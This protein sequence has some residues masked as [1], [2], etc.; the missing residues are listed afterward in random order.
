MVAG[1]RA[2]AYLPVGANGMDGYLTRR[3]VTAPLLLLGVSFILFLLLYVRWPQ[4]PALAC[5]GP[6]GSC[7]VIKVEGSARWPDHLG[8][9]APWYERYGAWLWD[10]LRGDL[11]ESFY[12][13]PFHP[14]GAGRSYLLPP[15]AIMAI[16]GLWVLGALARDIRNP[17]L[18][19]ATRAGELARARRLSLLTLSAR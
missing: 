19:I 5:V 15:V 11:G 7:F 17:H 13:D 3:L 12:A 10:A 1:P 9:N 2:S 6:V 18:R 14:H 4:Q 16:W 8:L